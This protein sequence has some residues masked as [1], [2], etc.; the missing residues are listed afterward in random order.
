MHIAAVTTVRN[1]CDIIESF[2]R[3]NAAFLDCLYI[4]DHRSTDSTPV[5]LRKLADE[6]LPLL[7]S[8]EDHGTFYQSSKMTQLIKRAF[9]DY[10]WDFVIPIDG[11]EFIRV[12]DRAALEAA[13][14]DLDR[15]GIGLLKVENYIPTENDDLNETD[16]LRR[17]VHRASTLP[18]IGSKLGKVVIPGGLIKRPGF[19]L[20]EGHHAVS[21]DGR[22]VPQHWL[23]AVSLAHFPVR[24]IDQFILRTSVCRLSWGS[25]SDYNP[26]W[27]WQYE[28][29]VEL[30]KRKP[31]LSAADLTEAA[32]VYVDI[33]GEPGEMR[34]HKVLVRQPVTPAYDRLR[35]TNSAGIA[36]LPPIL[37][38]MEFLLDELRAT[39]AA[40]AALSAS[41]T[42][43]ADG[44]AV[45]RVTA[46]AMMGRCSSPRHRFQSF[47]HGG[48]LS[49]YELFCLRSF[50]DWGHAVDL[51]TYDANL[52]VPAGVRVCDAAELIARDEVFVYQAEGFGKGSPSAFSNFFRYK[53]LVEK[54]GWWIDTDVVCLTDRIPAADDFFARQDADFV[55]P[56]TMYFEPNHPVMRQCLDQAVKLGRN[57][58]WGDTGPRLFTRV[59]DE[60]GWLDRAAAASV[61]YP[62]HYTRAL[63]VLRPARTADLTAQIE[64]ALFL[65]VWNS[66]LVHHG[67]QKS[68]R[69]PKGSL[70]RTLTDRHPVNGWIA[71]YDEHSLEHGLSLKAELNAIAQELNA[72][73]QAKAQLQVAFGS[74][75]AETER[76]Q[77][78][79]ER[80]HLQLKAVLTS[81][82]WRLTAPLRAG[83]DFFLRRR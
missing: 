37:D 59:L 32:L 17:I 78:S 39:R 28:K 79:F 31:T 33:Y 24:S 15:A 10:P 83:G 55:A 45:D 21:V 47:W 70:L 56:G 75:V 80:S 8:R 43:A 13:L 40:S 6:G 7:L 64:S 82:S 27:G 68:Y 67:V 16:V 76:L 65:H 71:E 2:V 58:K 48:P 61:C 36:L 29:F 73:T 38:M 18:D 30:L 11:D 44:A 52:V 41:E 3:H 49:P 9:D 60:R 12:P 74:Q 63:E 72:I 22:P 4:L 23:D 20:N 62:I 26:G 57:V 5:I 51:Y 81:T 14:A 66:T 50:I 69:P 1:E 53:L 19:V 54:G 46:R 42:E 35:Y 77:A 25:R 34:H